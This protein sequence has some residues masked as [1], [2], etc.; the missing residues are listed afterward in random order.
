MRKRLGMMSLLCLLLLINVTVIATSVVIAHPFITEGVFDLSSYSFEQEGPVSLNAPWAFYW[1]VLLPPD[2]IQEATPLGYFP[3]PSGW[4]RYTELDL[5][6]HGVATYSL[7]VQG[8]PTPAIYGLRVPNVYSQYSL[9]VNGKLLH[10]CGSFADQN[11]VYLH[12]QTFYFETSSTQIELVVQVENRELSYGGGVGQSIRFG[13]W[14]AIQDEDLFYN[15]L[16]LFLISVFFLSGAYFLIHH[17]FR[18]HNKEL[19]WMGILCLTVALRNLLSNTTLLMQY[20]PETPFWLGSKLIMLTVPV[21]LGSMLL[22]TRQLYRMVTPQR[23]FLLFLLLHGGYAL[24]VLLTSSTFYVAAFTPYLGVVGLT[25]V[26]GLWIGGQALRQKRDEASF[27]FYGMLILVTGAV[28]DSL[29]YLGILTSRYPFPF[30]LF[31]FIF[32][33][34]LLLAKRYNQAFLRSEGLAADLRHSLDRVMNTETAYM[35]AQMKPHFVFNALST[36]AESCSTEPAKAEALILS[37]SKYLRQTLDYERL[38]GFVSL[39]NEID[40]VHAYVAIE[41]ARFTNIE[42]VWQLPELLPVLRIPPLTLQP[43]VENAIKHGLRGKRKGGRVE[44][45]L[46]VREGSVFFT[47]QDDGVGMSEEQIASLLQPPQGSQ[48]IGLYNIHTRLVRFYG[49]GLQIHGEP[50]VGTW[51]HFEIPKGESLCSRPSLSTTK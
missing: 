13:P 48:S 17:Y 10:A 40:L 3:L 45:S 29:V 7:L 38:T 41:K 36:I 9:W 25:C 37:L 21:M 35:G 51:V 27:F 18:R 34:M 33:Q 26:F 12:P 1:N 24:L 14:Q 8:V 47:V 44:I 50:G 43:L 5:P 15:S 19:L 32:L 49:K 20:L 4:M 39:Q 28:L 16:D 46:E 6:I 2:Q 22:Y 30:A 23:L 42:V 11:P 31:G